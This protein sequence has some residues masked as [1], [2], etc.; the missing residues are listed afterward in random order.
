[1]PDV[2]YSMTMS[3]DGYVTDAD[4]SFDWGEPDE[5]LHRFHNQR[6]GRQGAQLMGRRLYEVMRWWDTPAALE[7]EVTRQFAEIWRPLPKVVFST[8]LEAVDGNARLASGGLAEEIAEL[9]THGGDIGIGGATLAAS[10]LR[11]GLVDELQLFVVPILVGG[12]T[13]FFPPLDEH[14]AL[15]LVETRTFGT[16]VTYLR[17]RV[18]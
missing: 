5:D 7:G 12:G 11:A 17:Y 6:V 15:D 18:S 2:I 8:T 3:L 1:M 9:K 10:A 14:V 16:G 4:G 13:P